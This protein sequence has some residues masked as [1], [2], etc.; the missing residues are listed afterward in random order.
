MTK[1]RTTISPCRAVV[2]TAKTTTTR[3]QT[4][5]RT[6]SLIFQLCNTTR[7]KPFAKSLKRAPLGKK[8]TNL[9]STSGD[10]ESGKTAKE[11]EKSTNA[12]SKKT[13]GVALVR[14]KSS[15]RPKSAGARSSQRLP[16]EATSSTKKATSST[17]TENGKRIKKVSLFDFI[18]EWRSSLASR[19]TATRR[20]KKRALPPRTNE[21]A[22]RNRGRLRKMRFYAP[23]STSLVQ[24]GRLWPMRLALRRA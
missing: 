8:R 10:F 24:I 1:T 19:R 14:I 17:K 7:T 15:R 2:R 21:K 4:L 11:R 22:P 6:F 9:P 20:G 5:P 12:V 16:R 18:R 13:Q 23:S 3:N